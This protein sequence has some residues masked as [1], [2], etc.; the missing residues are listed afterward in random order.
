MGDVGGPC[1][2]FILRILHTK[3]YLYIYIN[4]YIDVHTLYQVDKYI[5]NFKVQ[6]QNYKVQLAHAQHVHPVGNICM[7]LSCFCFCFCFFFPVLFT[8]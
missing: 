2:V 8:I 4:T 1:R 7:Y 3:I 5:S 6:K